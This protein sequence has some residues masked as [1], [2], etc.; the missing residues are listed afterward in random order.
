MIY[1][2]LIVLAL[3]IHSWVPIAVAILMLLIASWPGTMR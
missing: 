1:I 2:L 3:L